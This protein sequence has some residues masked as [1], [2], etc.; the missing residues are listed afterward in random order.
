MERR[1]LMALVLACVM[2]VGLCGCSLFGPDLEPLYGTWTLVEYVS[3]EAA[4]DMLESLDFYE[5]EI[6]LADLTGVGLVKEASFSEGTYSLTYNIE[7]SR[8]RMYNY[9]DQLILALYNGRDA[10][11]LDYGSEITSLT[12]DEFK[13]GYAE[14]F[15]LSSYEELLN[16]YV[17]NC[18]NYSVLE[19]SADIG[20]LEPG[21]GK[22]EILCNSEVLRFSIS[23]DELTL[24]YVDGME[25]YTRK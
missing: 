6:A 21:T 15:G 19:E 9:F 17:D 10:L 11:V 4:A 23:G 14:L 22:D 7:E 1:K 5:S 24:I 12:E 13:Q 2:L 18:M 20:I 25:V 16:M 3:E 8:A